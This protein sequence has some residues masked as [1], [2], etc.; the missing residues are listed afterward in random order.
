[1]LHI[2]IRLFIHIYAASHACFEYLQEHMLIHCFVSLYLR[3]QPLH[4]IRGKKE[5]PATCVGLVGLYFKPL[6]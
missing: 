2:R 4:T 5:V 1:M 3:D 6:L